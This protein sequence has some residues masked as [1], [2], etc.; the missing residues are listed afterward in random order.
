MS[1]VEHLLSLSKIEPALAAHLESHSPPITSSHP[2][3]EKVVKRYV[4]EVFPDRFSSYREFAAASMFRKR[5]LEHSLWDPFLQ[6]CN[7][8]VNFEKAAEIEAGTI[9][10]LGNAISR[11]FLQ[12]AKGGDAARLAPEAGDT[13]YQYGWAHLVL[14]RMLQ[15]LDNSWM[16]L[17]CWIEFGVGLHPY[18][19]FLEP[20]LWHTATSE[21]HTHTQKKWL[22]FSWFHFLDVCRHICFSR[23]K[24][25]LCYLS[26]LP[27]S[28]RKL[29]PS[30]HHCGVGMMMLTCVQGVSQWRYLRYMFCDHHSHSPPSHHHHHHHHRG[31]GIAPSKSISSEPNGISYH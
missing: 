30:K 24:C 17:T 12:Y 11:K 8:N 18:T 21:S 1:F 31:F 4:D 13:S 14:W 16:Q 23:K 3:Y 2:E 7:S 10:K 22:P 28:N 27:T 6:W 26:F 25:Y 5:M 15:C 20:E 9:Y 19:I 29:F